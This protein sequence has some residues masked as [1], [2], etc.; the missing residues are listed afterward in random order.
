MHKMGT[1]DGRTGLTENN[2]LCDHSEVDDHIESLWMVVMNRW[3]NTD[4]LLEGP[5]EL[6]PLNRSKSVSSMA[7]A[8]P[9][10]RVNGPNMEISFSI[11]HRVALKGI[12]FI[13]KKEDRVSLDR[14][15]D[16]I[17]KYTN[18]LLPR[19]RFWECIGMNKDSQDFAAVLFDALTL[20]RNII[21][22][23]INKA[24][25][26][27]FWGQI[28]DN[29]SDSSLQTF[30]DM[31]DEDADGRITQ[32]DVRK[33]ISLSASTNKLSNIKDQADEYAKFIMKE[34]DPDDLGYIMIYNLEMLLWQIPQSNIRGESQ[35][36]SLKMKPIRSCNPIRRLYEDFSF[37]KILI[38]GPYGGAAAQYYKK[39]EVVL[40]VGSGTPIIN[41]VKDILN[42]IK[43][44]EDQENPLE[45][46]STGKLQKKKSGEANFKTTKT[47]FY[48]VT[49]EQ[50][51]FDM[52]KDIINEAAEMDKYG[53]IEMHA[54]C[55]SVFEEDD[56]RSTI[57][58]IL[59]SL[60]HARNGI[61]VVSGTRVK[62]RFSEPNW[63]EV[64]KQITLN[65][66][67]SR[68]GVFYCGESAPAKEL[69][70]LAHD[71]SQKTSTKFDFHKQNF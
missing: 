55:T 25:M 50:G 71:F 22:D 3:Q 41:I 62:S 20:R 19:L 18:G 43:A 5:E 54:Y 39:Y 12:K 66:V 53:V 67:G 27:E 26:R 68:I 46:G 42:N 64:Y 51:S 31:I 57:I 15:F 32:D 35:Y 37:P 4:G 65:H 7:Q 45:N 56:A 69:K 10:S 70:Q 13:S 36:L 52:V 23:S 17:T 61:D 59:Q 48:W 9:F 63:R 40:L 33:I 24:K 16:D 14:R 1:D 2:K 28:S 58:A 49:S 47:Y 29:S 11:H 60:Y 34:L 44:K 21:G 30:F 8:S 6:K 38:N